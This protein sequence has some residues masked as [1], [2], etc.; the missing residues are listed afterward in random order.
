MLRNILASI[1]RLIDALGFASGL[2]NVV[3]AIL[4]DRIF[5]PVN[6]QI[7]GACDKLIFAACFWPAIHHNLGT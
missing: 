3:L 6:R 7:Y 5:A 4:L 2:V 1:I